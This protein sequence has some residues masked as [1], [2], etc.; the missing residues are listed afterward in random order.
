MLVSIRRDSVI[1]VKMVS[2]SFQVKLSI[3][4]SHLRAP[5]FYLSSRFMHP[6]KKHLF[7]SFDVLGTVL[8]MRCRGVME[9]ESSSSCGL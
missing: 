9:T 7:S 8:A 3:P 1:D 4:K 6:F 2:K 5:A